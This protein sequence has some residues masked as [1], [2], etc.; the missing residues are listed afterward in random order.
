MAVQ[1]PMQP[2]PWWRTRRGQ[3]TLFTTFSLTMALLGTAIIM[4]PFFWMLSTALKTASDVFLYPP[5]WLPIPPQFQNFPEALSLFPFHIYARNTFFIVAMVM[6]GNILS[7]SFSAYGFARLRA[8]GRD[9]IFM[10]LLATLM[11]P[12]VVTLVPTY[13]LFNRLGWINSFLPL[14]VPAFFGNAFFIFLL[15]QFYMTIPRELEEAA[16]IDGANNYRIWWN[17][18]LPLSQPVLATVAV[19][20]FIGTYNDF[21]GPLIYLTDD[22]KRTIAV[23]LSFFQG[24]PRVGP[25][26][27]LLMAAVTASIVPPLLLFIV[28][29][30]F[31]VR[32]IVMTGIKG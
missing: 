20:T 3:N 7:C 21:F 1:T 19:F 22:S 27:H 15:R 18:I 24:S 17:I 12:S 16:F 14:I 6:L 13:L 26:R 4:I 2:L 9:F 23:A 8:P 29:Q 10:I 11:L 28:A 30:R 25:Q 32:G 5:K 31:F